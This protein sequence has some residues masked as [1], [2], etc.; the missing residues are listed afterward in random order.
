[1][2]RNLTTIIQRGGRHDHYDIHVAQRSR[3]L[4]VRYHAI[5]Y[6]YIYIYNLIYTILLLNT[7]T[8]KIYCTHRY[9]QSRGCFRPRPKTSSSAL[10]INVIYS[11]CRE[12]N[13]K[14]RVIDRVLFPVFFLFVDN[15]NTVYLLRQYIYIHI[16][17]V[18]RSR[19]KD[20]LWVH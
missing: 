11:C 2:W 20:R 19:R 6:M 17:Y 12:K 14:N 5:S 4:A 16:I 9:I 18:D 3:V 10:Q 1:V 7:T 15:K 13:N 8:S